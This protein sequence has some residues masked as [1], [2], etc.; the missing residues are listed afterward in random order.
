MRIGVLGGGQLGRM[1]GLAGIP[2]GCQMSFYDDAIDIPARCTGIAVRA[3]YDDYEALRKFASGLD[4]VTYEFENIPV[5]AVQ[6]LEKHVKVY[7]G[8]RALEVSQDRVAEKEFLASTGAPVGQWMQVDS[9]DDIELVFDQLGPCIL[10][11]RRF[12]YDGKGQFRVKTP[13]DCEN[14]WKALNGLPSVAEKLILFDREVSLVGARSQSGEQRFWPLI[15]NVHVDGILHRSEAPAPDVLPELQDRAEKI[16]SNIM[17]SLDYVGVL[18]VE[19][20]V[21]DGHLLVNEMAPRVHNSGHWTIEGSVTSQFENHMRAVMGL[22]LGSTSTRFRSIMYNAIGTL[23]KQD[24]L[25]RIAGA[26]YH[27]YNKDPRENRKVGHVTI[28]D[29]PVAAVDQS[30]RSRAENVEALIMEARNRVG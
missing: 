12:G 13:A 4:A 14:G 24:E 18:T 20:F 10:K 9:A 6:M 22:S 16:V 29:E 7:P 28:C 1:L 11:T 5:E 25:C 15:E 3:R 30:F 23:P 21:L 2:L 8:S 17:A 19:F 27:S 26:H